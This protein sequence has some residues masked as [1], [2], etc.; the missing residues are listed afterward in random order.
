MAGFAAARQHNNFLQLLHFPCC[1]RAQREI[2]IYRL[3]W[4]RPCDS[5]R[6]AAF[7]RQTMLAT[8]LNVAPSPLSC[9]PA[10]KDIDL[11][12]IFPPT[13]AG[14]VCCWRANPPGLAPLIRTPMPTQRFT[15]PAQDIMTV[16]VDRGCACGGCYLF[17]AILVPVGDRARDGDFYPVL[18]GASRC[19]M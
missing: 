10:H 6:Q 17:S 5:V 16:S 3:G 4:K 15:D 9:T 1:E 2:G 12:L 13:A 11:R 19:R 14:F 7:T 8:L 18:L